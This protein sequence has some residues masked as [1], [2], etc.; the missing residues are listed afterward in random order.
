M[1]NFKYSLDN[2]KPLVIESY[3]KIEY[4]DKTYKR[5]LRISK[6]NALLI[7]E[8]FGFFIAKQNVKFVVMD[9]CDIEKICSYLGI[10]YKPI[11][12]YFKIDPNMCTFQ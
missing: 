9:L 11:E 7:D 12:T 5:R 8:K 3:R 1:E 6:M 2:F 4:K 10:E